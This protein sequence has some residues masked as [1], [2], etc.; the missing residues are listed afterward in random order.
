MLHLTLRLCLI[1]LLAWQIG[2][3]QKAVEPLP[4]PAPDL[5]Q[6]KLTLDVWNK[7]QDPEKYDRDTLRR[8]RKEE[9]SLK[10][11]E[12]WKT[13]HNTVVIPGIKK[14]FGESFAPKPL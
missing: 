5:S 3:G 9:P 4:E 2:C 13:F 10:S 12:N 11:N 7:I 6:M 1:A 14:E 8:L